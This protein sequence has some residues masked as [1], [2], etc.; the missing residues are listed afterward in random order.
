[1]LLTLALPPLP[2]AG[3]AIR[4]WLQQSCIT[5]QQTRVKIWAGISDWSCSSCKEN[6][7]PFQLSQQEERPCLP[8]IMAVLQK[9]KSVPSLA[10]QPPQVNQKKISRKS[11]N[12]KVPVAVN[13]QNH[14]MC[15]LN[16]RLKRGNGSYYGGEGQIQLSSHFT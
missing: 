10:N 16:R 15:D 3:I 12:F 14:S 4:R 9:R 6:F 13:L 1:M 2:F 8:W 11:G 5:F 7:C